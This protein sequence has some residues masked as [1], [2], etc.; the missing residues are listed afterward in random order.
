MS[1]S[2]K[3]RPRCEPPR[4]SPRLRVQ[5]KPLP[6]R[7]TEPA[8]H[9]LPQAPR[10][11]SGPEEPPGAARGSPRPPAAGC[12]AP[13]HPPQHRNSRPEAQ[14]VATATN[15]APLHPVRHFRSPRLLRTPLRTTPAGSNPPFAG[16]GGDPR[17][18]SAHWDPP[19]GTVLGHRE[20]F[21]V[22]TI[23]WRQAGH[24]ARGALCS[25]RNP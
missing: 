8:K 2:W 25:V 18:Q 4:S 14:L 19:R 21:H 10:P 12:A 17:A 5:E 6:V 7:L 15:P 1:P 3:R 16:G 23:P 9:P 13:W 11:P 22:G 20:G 24:G